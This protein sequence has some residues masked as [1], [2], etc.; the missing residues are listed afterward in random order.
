MK[1]SD[2]LER[3]CNLIL[4]FLFSSSWKIVFLIISFQDKRR[5][6]FTKRPEARPKEAE[7]IKYHRK[8]TE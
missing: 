2:T 4:L 3:N 7:G 1:M 8:K 5:K 6:Y